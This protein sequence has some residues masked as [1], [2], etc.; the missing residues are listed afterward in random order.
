M[1]YFKLGIFLKLRS[2]RKLCSKRAFHSN[3]PFFGAQQD[4]G[5]LK[6]W[7]NRYFTYYNQLAFTNIIVT[8]RSDAAACVATP[9]ALLQHNF[10]HFIAAPCW[11]GWESARRKHQVSK[12]LR[13]PCR[14]HDNEPLTFLPPP[15]T[16]RHCSLRPAAAGAPV[17]QGV[18]EDITARGLRK[19]R[20]H[21]PG[22]WI[23]HPG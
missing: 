18:A 6:S 19:Q 4:D 9:L 22:S 2:S 1:I 3:S 20:L 15:D 8:F 11:R 23:P 13:H 12:F 10:S 14:F 17:A 7:A 16:D 5:S 21:L